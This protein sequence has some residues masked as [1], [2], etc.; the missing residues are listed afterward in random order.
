MFLPQRR[1][2][3]SSSPSRGRDQPVA[4]LHRRSCD[5]PRLHLSVWSSSA[6][7]AK[8]MGAIRAD[9]ES[10]AFAARYQAGDVGEMSVEDIAGH[11]RTGA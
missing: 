4:E 1:W 5:R 8:G 9:P 11:G 10:R 6:G 3:E 2:L 7:L